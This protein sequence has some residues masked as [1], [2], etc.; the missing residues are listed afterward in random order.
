MG[1]RRA[2]RAQRRRRGAWRAAE[3]RGGRAAL[4]RLASSQ[5]I[6]FSHSGK[7]DEL[8]QL[9]A[10]F[11]NAGCCVVSVVGDLDSPLAAAADFVRGVGPGRLAD[12]EAD[13]SSTFVLH[14]YRRS[15]SRP[16][17]TQRSQ[18]RRAASSHRLGTSCELRLASR[19]KCSRMPP[20]VQE[21]FCNALVEFLTENLDGAHES[22]R[23]S[24]PG[25][26]IGRSYREADES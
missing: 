4:T 18:C 13:H 12:T 22:L 19:E 5:V 25:G 17:T 10:R 24:H 16:T 11:R 15:L 2:R 14:L 8:L 6:I 9:P 3:G 7:T 26:E 23:R 1:P 21:A 20:T